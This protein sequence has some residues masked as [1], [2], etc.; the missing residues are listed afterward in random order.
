M[1]EPGR[2]CA[3][4]PGNSEYGGPALRNV[5]RKEK[6]VQMPACLPRL[7]DA[8]VIAESTGRPSSMCI[9]WRKSDAGWEPA[10]IRNE[11]SDDGERYV[12]PVM[13]TVRFAEDWGP[14]RRLLASS[15]RAAA[16]R[17]WFARPLEMS[18]EGAVGHDA[19]GH[20]FHG[21]SRTEMR[22]YRARQS[23]RFSDV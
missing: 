14:L 21:K 13:K 2:L 6:I 3:P 23:W 19:L 11:Y 17:G 4:S 16:Q 18:F 22:T 12:C 8:D 9:G 1:L 7:V 20:H 15:H 5:R 10:A